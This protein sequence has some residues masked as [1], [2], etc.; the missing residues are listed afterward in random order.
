MPFKKCLLKWDGSTLQWDAKG[1]SSGSWIKET[2]SSLFLL[3]RAGRNF[4]ITRAQWMGRNRC[5][6]FLP[7]RS[8]KGLLWAVLLHK[9]TE[10][11]RQMPYSRSQVVLGEQTFPR[12]SS[13][14][15]AGITAFFLFYLMLPC[16]YKKWTWTGTRPWALWW[17]I[18]RPVFH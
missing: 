8:Q 5:Q 4:R 10:S 18:L 7:G 9:N 17:R 15:T 12:V 1:L 3:S 2:L 6:I 14:A 16:A 13:S 11:K